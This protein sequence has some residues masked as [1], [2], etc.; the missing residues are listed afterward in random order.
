MSRLLLRPL[1]LACLLLP[2][3]ACTGLGGNLLTPRVKVLDVRPLTAD[4][5]AQR[6]T[7][8]V[9]VQNP[10]DLELP[11]RG[12]DYQL[13][14]MGD[15]FAE[16]VSNESFLLPALGEA[17]FD[18]TV[19]TNFMSALG[20]LVSRAGGG[21]LDKI[22]YEFTGKIFV[23][24]GVLRKIPFSQQGVLDFKQALGAPKQGRTAT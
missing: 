22:E 18:M 2:A 15:S 16:G 21:K 14:L 9:L 17:E 8:R 13:M 1:L 11:V 20:R 3:V 4:M 10:N 24:K 6:F 5:F 19:T 7:V 12:I 23:D